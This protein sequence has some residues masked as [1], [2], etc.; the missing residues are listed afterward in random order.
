MGD[1][2]RHI[3]KYARSTATPYGYNIQMKDHRVVNFAL[4][5]L[6][7]TVFSCSEYSN[8]KKWKEM[9]MQMGKG[10]SLCYQ[11]LY[12]PAMEG[13]IKVRNCQLTTFFFSGLLAFFL[14]QVQK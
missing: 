7:R 3:R 9:E 14:F 11:T 2:N 12:S 10:D 4:A 13:L 8:W 6:E 5:P 1:A